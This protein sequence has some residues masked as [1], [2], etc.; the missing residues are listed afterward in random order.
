MNAA[1]APQA[2]AKT[3]CPRC[4]KPLTDPA[5]MGWCQACGFC[6]SLE[7]DKAKVKVQAPAAQQAKPSNA[8]EAAKIATSIPRWFWPLLL[9]VVGFSA[10]SLLPAR[11]LA[12]NSLQRALWTTCQI[13]AGVFLI[14]LAQFIALVRIAPEDEKLSFKDVFMPTR[15]W[16]LV[17]KRLPAQ[18]F[19][20]WLA[21]WG[22]AISLSGGILIGGMDYWLTY[23]PGG[24]NAAK[25]T[26]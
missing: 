24:K 1:T 16:S 15:L 6:K 7:E 13:G 4:G 11:Q 12:P 26:K 5:G 18:K 25:K 23:L 14:F 22:L 19:A 2:P 21:G 17:F 8:A 9:G 3:P 10:A 20:L